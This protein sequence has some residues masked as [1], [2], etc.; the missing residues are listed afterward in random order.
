[1]SLGTVGDS[2]QNDPRNP[3]QPDFGALKRDA[4][5][6]GGLVTKLSMAIGT[7][8]EAKGFRHKAEKAYLE[9]EPSKEAS[10]ESKVFPNKTPADVLMGAVL[11]GGGAP[12]GLY[13]HDDYQGGRPAVQRIGTGCPV[14]ALR[15]ALTRASNP[16]RKLA[17][18]EADSYAINHS[19]PFRTVYEE[20]GISQVTLATLMF[21]F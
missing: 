17:P 18:T 11:S 12:G 14:P 1:M 19:T 3:N 21:M 8:Q 10:F 9:D 7:K 20:Q 5:A 6:I 4:D 2:N 13:T 15:P 16:G